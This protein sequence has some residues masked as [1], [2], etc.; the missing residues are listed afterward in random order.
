MQQYVVPHCVRKFWLRVEKLCDRGA[1]STTAV[2]R[3][4]T[5]PGLK[6]EEF[7]NFFDNISLKELLELCPDSGEH[8]QC[9]PEVSPIRTLKRGFPNEHPLMVS[10]W[11]CL[12]ND[13]MTALG[14]ATCLNIAQKQHYSLSTALTELLH[15][16]GNDL[17]PNLFELFRTIT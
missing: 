15:D 9:L 7:A 10:A 1:W 8:M 16:R 17:P 11:A 12:L 3:P 13:A 4:A 14:E 6:S 2:G 5:S